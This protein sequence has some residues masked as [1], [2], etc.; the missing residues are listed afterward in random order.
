MS[1]PQRLFAPA[2]AVVLS[3]ILAGAPTLCLADHH[4]GAAAQQEPASTPSAVVETLQGT[5]LAYMRSAS[6][7]ESRQDLDVTALDQAV[8]ASHDFAYISRIV[9]GR[10]WRELEDADRARFVERFT[11]LSLA[12]Y[13]SRFAEF[14]GERFDIND[15]SD[16]S[17][18]QRRVSAELITAEKSHSFDYL[19]R[20]SDEQWRIVNIIVDGVSDL[21]LKRAEYSTL[22][23]AGGFEGL[24]EALDRQRSALEEESAAS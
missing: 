16:G 17:F 15:E 12:T 9:L 19:L 4:E 23:S 2:A 22:I 20:Q 1:Y 21:A 14:A 5:L 24:L 3:A 13:A 10:T 6:T 8:L 11:A 18:G 7:A